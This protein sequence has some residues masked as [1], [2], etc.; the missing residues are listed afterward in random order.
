MEKI[1]ILPQFIYKFN[2]PDTQII[3]KIIWELENEEWQKNDSNYN[4]LNTLLHKN[5]KY[6]EICNWFYECVQKVKNDLSI[7]CDEIKITQCWA[8]KAH[9]GEWHHPHTHSNSIISGIFYLNNSNSN[10]WFSIP[11]FWNFIKSV[12]YNDINVKLSYENG[13]NKTRVIYKHPTTPGELIIFPSSLYHSV[14]DHLIMDKNRYSISFNTFPS[15]KIG[16]LSCLSGLEL[17]VK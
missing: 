12:D 2:F 14:D 8:N 13:L 3:S 10:T 9:Y 4:S 6:F 5:S 11:S 1:N 15:G 16:K 7:E 17:E